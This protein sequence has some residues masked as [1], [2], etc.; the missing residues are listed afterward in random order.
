MAWKV[1]NAC[2]VL[3]SKFVQVDIKYMKRQINILSFL[4]ILT[5]MTSCEGFKVLTIHNSSEYEA[6]VTVRPGL[7]FSNNKPIH[8]YPNI[9]TSDSTI[10]VL[11]PDSSITI[12]SVFKGMMF[13]V[14]IKENELRTNFLKIETSN[15]TIIANSRSEILGL[16]KNEKTRY[17]PKMDKDK[18]LAN[19]RNFGNIFIRK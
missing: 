16:L 15:D 10:V 11:Q 12:L 9:Q 4:F 3:F 5:L 19:G 18:V 1:V 2:F 6:K 13:N 8:N 17:K 7:D 14:K